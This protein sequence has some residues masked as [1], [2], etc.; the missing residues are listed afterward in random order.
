M[1]IFVSRR[2]WGTTKYLQVLSGLFVSPWRDRT[3][4]LMSLSWTTDNL[5]LLGIHIGA[6]RFLNKTN[7]QGAIDKMRAVL[8]FWKPRD[9]SLAGCSYV[10]RTLVASKLWYVAQVV[11]GSGHPSTTANGRRD[12]HDHVE[13]YLERSRRTS[14]PTS[15]LSDQAQRRVGWNRK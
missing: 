14:M 9:L 8:H 15:L 4:R 10:A 3:D 5:K 13:I 12:Q 2:Q 1:F 11:R 7:W 6:T